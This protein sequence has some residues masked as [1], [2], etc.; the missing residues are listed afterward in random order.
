M[1]SNENNKE[2]WK[3]IENYEGLYEVSDH[4]RVKNSRTGRI[5]KQQEHLKYMH[6]C[7]SKNGKNKRHRV[8]RLV[9]KSFIPNPYSKPHVHH[10]DE[11]E[12]NNMASNLAWV[13]QKENVN[14]G[15]AQ[16][17][18]MASMDYKAVAKKKWKPVDQ[19]DLTG[20]LIRHW[21]SQLEIYEK[22]G[23]NRGFISTVCNRIKEKAYGFVWRFAGESF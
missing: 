13:T 16:K 9:A 3:P 22:L 2:N 8:H 17:K 20:N 7:L 14:A 11:Q 21:R 5:L 1:R 4:G 12:W 10:I 23:F 15:D 19:Y 18:R 6:V